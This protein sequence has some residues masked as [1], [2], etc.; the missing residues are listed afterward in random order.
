MGG[1]RGRGGVFWR[2]SVP[3]EVVGGHRAVMLI[4]CFSLGGGRRGHP[5]L[6]NE[7]WFKCALSGNPSLD[8]TPDRI[9]KFSEEKRNEA[10]RLL[11]AIISRLTL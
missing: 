1:V 9:G 3:W 2:S 7:K 10:L 5:A 11:S 6:K 8:P 4:P